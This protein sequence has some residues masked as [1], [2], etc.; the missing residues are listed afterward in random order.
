MDAPMLLSDKQTLLDAINWPLVEKVLSEPFYQLL[1]NKSLDI[2]TL[3]GGSYLGSNL[4]NIFINLSFSTLENELMESTNRDTN[5][6]FNL[7]L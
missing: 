1:E 5:Y 3:L 2:V 7:I 6:F 4:F